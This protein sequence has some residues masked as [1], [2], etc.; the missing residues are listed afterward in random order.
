MIKRKEDTNIE[1]KPF[2]RYLTK[3]KLLD[4]LYK[5]GFVP[6]MFN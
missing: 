5:V 6:P 3:T 4:A 2:D 1:N